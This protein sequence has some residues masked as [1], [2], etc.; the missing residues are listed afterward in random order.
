MSLDL[1]KTSSLLKEKFNDI[2][3]ISFDKCEID[4]NFVRFNADLTIKKFNN[5][6]ILF[7]GKIGNGGYGNYE[8][9]FDE[10]VIS[11][12]S[13][14]AI[15]AFNNSHDLLTAFVSRRGSAGKYY[16][17]LRK[18]LQFGDSEDTMVAHAVKTLKDVIDDDNAEAIKELLT[19]LK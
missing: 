10:Y 16:L 11:E 1:N 9:V 3:G 15:N 17:V 8:V 5:A 7:A 4:G 18:A 13:L 19:Y 6:S 12:D 2:F 14:V